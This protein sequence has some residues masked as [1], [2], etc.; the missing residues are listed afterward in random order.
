MIRKADVLVIVLI[1]LNLCAV[2]LRADI[3][4]LTPNSNS[5]VQDGIEYYVQTDKAVYDLGENVEM[6]YRVTNLGDEDVTLGLVVCDPL[7]YYD[8]RIMQD[9]S[10]IWQYPYLSVVLGFTFFHLGPYESKEGQ[11]IWNMMNDNGT[12]QTDDDFPVNP[13]IY[14]VIG[15]LDLVSGER[16]PVSVSIQII[17]EPA[18]FLFLVFGSLLLT[19]LS[20]YR[21]TKYD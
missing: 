17:P 16:V 21:R 20:Q 10:Q 6:L 4:P 8:F 13:G 12:L 11:T 2:N 3:V 5:I 14:N 9:G 19:N 1:V 18:T 7:A 15:E